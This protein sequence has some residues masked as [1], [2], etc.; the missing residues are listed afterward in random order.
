MVFK[1]GIASRFCLLTCFAEIFNVIQEIMKR[2]LFLL[3]FFNSISNPLLAS[4]N[5]KIKGSIA[6][7][8]I[9]MEAMA[10]G[11]ADLAH[12]TFSA[13]LKEIISVAELTQSI[14]Y[15][16]VKL[17]GPLNF[18]FDQVFWYPKDKTGQPNDIIVLEYSGHNSFGDVVCGYFAFALLSPN[19]FEIVRIEE[20]YSLKDVIRNQSKESVEE[21]KS[22]PGCSKIQKIAEK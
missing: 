19:K 6:L 20:F 22:Y 7:F 14:F 18:S 12:K 5:E 3:F 2:L 13:E 10:A 4:E 8:K 1:D 9:Y 15:K 11:D 16:G 17:Q 21:I